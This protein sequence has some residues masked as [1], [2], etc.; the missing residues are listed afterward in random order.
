MQYEVSKTVL[1]YLDTAFRSGG[2]IGEPVFTFPNNLINVLPQKGERLRLTMQEASIEYTFFQT[3][4]FNNKMLIL[5]SVSGGD[6]LPRLLEIPIGNYNITTFISVLKTKLNDGTLYVYELEFIPET[7]KLLYTATPQD[8]NASLGNITFNFDNDSAFNIFQAPIDESLN[9]MMGY[10]IDEIAE[11]T[12]DAPPGQP[13]TALISTSTVPITMSPGVENL[14]VTVQNS[15]SNYG[16]VNVVN[17][18]TSSNILAKI[19]VS[20]PP[21]STLY[22]YD[23]NGNFSTLISNSYL[24]NLNLTLF[25]ERFTK[26]E[27][28]K[29]WTFTIKIEVLRPARHASETKEGIQEL[30]NMTKMKMIKKNQPTKPDEQ[31]VN[32]LFARKK[33]PVAQPVNTLVARKKPK[34]QKPLKTDENT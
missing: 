9:E 13:A 30:V 7:N 14:Y 11:F 29:N 21:F 31:P 20:S 3:E 8:P 19:P 5:E 25:N 26:I 28:R 12:L 16:N 10:D 27:P 2:T 1:F 34:V 24:D 6:A 32:T 23:V 15:C 33:N 17:T 4:E 22:F 18:F